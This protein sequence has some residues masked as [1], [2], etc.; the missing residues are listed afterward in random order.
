MAGNVSTTASSKLTEFAMNSI[1]IASF[2]NAFF[3]PTKLM[4]C[5]MLFGALVFSSVPAARATVSLPKI[6]G[7]HMVLQRNRPIRIWGWAAP[8][9]EVFVTLGSV[10]GAAHADQNGNWAIDLPPM[11]AGGPFQMTVKGTNVIEI[12]DI[13]IGDLWVASGQSNMELPLGGTPQAKVNN[14]EQEIQSATHP[15]IRLFHVDKV[16]S[17]YPLV[18]LRQK[19]GW[20]ICSPQS[21]SDFSAVAYFFGRELASTEKVPVGLIDSS[22]GGTPAEAWISLSGLTADASLISAFDEFN[23]MA[24]IHG[25]DMHRWANEDAEDAL[26]KRQ[27]LPTPVRNRNHGFDS[28]APGTLFNGMIFPL[29]P[30]RIRGVIWYQGEA[31]TTPLRAPIYDRLF[32]AM[33]QDWRKKWQQNDLPFLFVQLANWNA[34]SAQRWPLVREA[35]RRALSLP[36]TAMAVTIDVGDSDNIHPGNKQAV[37]HR[38]ALAARATVYQ[39]PIEFSGPLFFE[40]SLETGALRVW[41]THADGLHTSG[42][43]VP[44][45]ELAG[46]DHV[47]LP[48]TEARIE[49]ETILL[50]NPKIPRPVYARY[51]WD[52]DPKL[53]LY[54]GASLLASPFSSAD[55]QRQ[56]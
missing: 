16:A 53:D 9:E 43:S 41:F 17:T 11:K 15:E 34:H 8:G 42:Q 38:L 6:I 28:A 18:D 44:G 37:G 22:W 2:V 45:I 27:G 47:F 19:G 40:A 13:L 26:A 30:M 54:N 51:G 39:E 52:D 33:I 10:Q 24:F 48:A 3:P 7:D 49:G 14:A 23:S 36:D 35:Q 1:Y 5:A 55:E 32:P 31:N 56:K 25:Q 50:S 46:D 20:S 12:E 4:L 29:L 21:V